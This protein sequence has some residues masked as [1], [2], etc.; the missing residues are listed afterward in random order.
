M[1]RWKLPAV[2]R[3]HAVRRPA[4]A[5]GGRQPS[6]G[7][8]TVQLENWKAAH[9]LACDASQCELDLRL[10]IATK[11]R[12]VPRCGPHPKSC[13][14]DRELAATISAGEKVLIDA[15]SD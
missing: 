7:S 15:L 6:E 12:R 1:G 9:I 4:N 8:Q 3:H 11:R 13:P 10:N 14:A 2:E 5:S